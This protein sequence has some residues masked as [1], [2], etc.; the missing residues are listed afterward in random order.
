ME[1]E[2]DFKMNVENMV[3]SAQTKRHSTSKNVHETILKYGLDY[4][5]ECAKKGEGVGEKINSCMGRAY[6]GR[7]VWHT[8]Y[9]FKLMDAMKEGGIF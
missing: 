3:A 8:D 2:N 5:A 1:K 7:F 6:D 9:Q 4:L